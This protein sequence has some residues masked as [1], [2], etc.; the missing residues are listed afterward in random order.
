MHSINE[1]KN[2][3]EENR[4]LVTFLLFSY[5]QENYIREAVEGVL[6]QDYES[7]EIIISNSKQFFNLKKDVYK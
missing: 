5:N 3:S 1:M 2:L 7:L 6:S 4:P